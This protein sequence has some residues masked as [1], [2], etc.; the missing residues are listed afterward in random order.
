VGF[1]SVWFRKI[2]GIKNKEIGVELGEI[3]VKRNDL[4]NKI[5]FFY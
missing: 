4:K 2:I 1:P 5:I 3:W